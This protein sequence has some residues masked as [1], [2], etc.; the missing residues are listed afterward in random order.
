MENA[1]VTYGPVLILAPFVLLALGVFFISLVPVGLWISAKCAGVNISLIQLVTMKWKKV[2]PEV[3]VR[4]MIMATQ[5]KLNEVTLSALESY[6]LQGGRVGSVVCALIAASRADIP[7]TFE[8]ACAIDRAGRDVLDAVRMSVN[9]KV[10]ETPQIAAV[11]QDGIELVA[12]CRVTV[13]ANIKQLVGGAGEE[14][15]L[16]RVQEGICTAIGSAAHFQD[17][18][19]SPDLISKTV[20][21][22]GLDRG[23]AFEILSID[24]ADVDVGRN[25]GAELQ[26]NQAEADKEIAQASAETRRSNAEAHEQEMK[27]KLQAMKARVAEAQAEVPEAMGEAL[28][29]GK[30]SI[31]NYYNLK[32]LLAD[33]VMRQ[34]LSTKSSNMNLL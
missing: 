27:A 1:I 34:S 6:Y 11:A 8:D 7:L 18:L 25:I 32:N 12:M 30:L 2:P 26:I 9:P 5:A 13:R 3:V 33:T 20:L 16:A 19:E 14:T 4:P 29:N 15:I 17:V 21:E 22:K 28:L 31:L 23:T 24:I 10:I